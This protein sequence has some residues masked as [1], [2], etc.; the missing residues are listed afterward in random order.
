MLTLKIEHPA[1]LLCLV[2][3]LEA[4]LAERPPIEP[5]AAHAWLEY[6][7]SG[8]LIGVVVELDGE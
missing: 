1:E 2:H 6:S 5:E 4:A 8:D 7:D 3:T